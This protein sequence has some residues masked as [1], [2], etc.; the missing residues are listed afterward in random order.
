V[1]GQRRR[2]WWKVYVLVGAGAAVVAV[3]YFSL[4]PPV[5][6]PTEAERPAPLPPVAREEPARPVWARLPV[7]A[8][9][10]AY[11]PLDGR[12][13]PDAGEGLISDDEAVARAAAYIGVEDLSSVTVSLDR[14]I[15]EG[16]RTPFLS[17]MVN[18]RRCYIVTF[19]GVDIPKSEDEVHRVHTLNALVDAET[20]QLLKLWSS[21]W[22]D[23]PTM[24]RTAAQ[25]EAEIGRNGEEWQGFPEQ[26]PKI[27]LLELLDMTGF[28]PHMQQLDAVYVTL[29]NRRPHWLVTVRD[30]SPIYRVDEWP[31]LAD[32]LRCGISVGCHPDDAD[33]WH[34]RDF[35]AE[36]Q[37]IQFPVYG[38]RMGNDGETGQ[39]YSH[40]N[41]Y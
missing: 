10:E 6:E 8:G 30:T 9:D 3:L 18:G 16:D 26:L 36:R 12:A 38:W 5:T 4:F 1:E 23:P 7:R 34:G 31:E 25:V 24:Q 41:F 19:G 22:L 32:G 27:S 33:A 11:I 2:K 14:V 35:D 15:P 40:S 37:T 13:W 17:S 28:P 20:G 39:L 29:H 21:E